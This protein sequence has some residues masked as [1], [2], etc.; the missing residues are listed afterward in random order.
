MGVK[1]DDIKLKN[2]TL[3]SEYFRIGCL[4]CWNPLDFSQLFCSPCDLDPG[5]GELPAPVGVG[6]GWRSG[7]NL[8]LVGSPRV[9]SRLYYH[10]KWLQGTH[11]PPWFSVLC[12]KRNILKLMVP[13]GHLKSWVSVFGICLGEKRKDLD[14]SVCSDFMFLDMTHLGASCKWSFL[15]LYPWQ[16]I[17][18]W[19]H[20]LWLCISHL[21]SMW[22]SRKISYFGILESWIETQTMSLIR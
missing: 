2:C 20:S 12:C 5:L 7:G 19:D 13:N 16:S 4:H 1:V 22:Y 9:H 11:L 21:E 8:P 3:C 18:S 10:R 15:L 14:G 6:A 17:Y